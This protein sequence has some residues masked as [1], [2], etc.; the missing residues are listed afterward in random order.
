[1]VHGLFVVVH[2]LLSSVCMGFSLV[3]AHGFQ[4]VRVPECVG[5]VVVAHRL[6]D[7]GVWTPECMGSLVVLCC[8]QSVWDL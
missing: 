6:S 5:S 7:C 1:M 8:L 3:V 4:G 2:G